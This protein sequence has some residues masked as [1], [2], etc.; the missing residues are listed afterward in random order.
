MNFLIILVSGIAV[1]ALIVTGFL[2]VTSS[3]DAE[4]KSQAKTAFKYVIIGFIIIFI[5]W[6]IIDFFL[7][8]FGYLDPLGGEW[9]VICE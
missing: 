4:R 5:A 8:A 9:N 2:Y 1:L 7:V 6:I 3:G